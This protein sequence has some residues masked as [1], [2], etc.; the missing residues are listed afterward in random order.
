M[1]KVFQVFCQGL[2]RSKAVWVLFYPWHQT[3][4]V[5]EWVLFDQAISRNSL[6]IRSRDICEGNRCV[7]LSY[8]IDLTFDLTTMILSF[9]IL[10][11]LYLRSSKMLKV[12]HL[13][14]LS[15]GGVG[16]QCHGITLV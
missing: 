11:E 15:V 9:K 3:G 4:Y 13:A 6:G 7:T 12:D 16:V 10:Q 14:G 1:F 8:H 5:V 2:K